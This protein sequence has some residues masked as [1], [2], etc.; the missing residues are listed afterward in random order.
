MITL[1]NLPN[2]AR[3]ILTGCAAF[4]FLVL[5]AHA[6]P[7]TGPLERA[8]AKQATMPGTLAY[9]IHY[10]SDA[11]QSEFVA[12]YTP[13]QTDMPWTVLSI[14]DPTQEQVAAIIERI[15][16]DTL[17]DFSTGLDPDDAEPFSGLT[18]THADNT[19][20]YDFGIELEIGDANKS[21]KG[22]V[23]ASVSVDPVSEQ[24]THSHIYSTRGFRIGTAARIKSLEIETDYTS[25]A[26]L[27][28]AVITNRRSDVQGKALLFS[29]WSLDYNA[30]YSD[31]AIIE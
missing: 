21:V 29:N 8:L 2:I 6:E 23:R 19:V 9:T 16:D 31:F 22:R 5:A 17:D 30:A 1:P 27:D 3:I 12:R 28:A 11:W 15:T 20:I 14:T 4:T 25:I 18:V 24:L 13:K 26:G 7:D 10:K